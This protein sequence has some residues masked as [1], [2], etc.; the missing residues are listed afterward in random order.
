MI[1]ILYI[2]LALVLG[3][4]AGII[5]GLIPGIHVNLIAVFLMLTLLTAYRVGGNNRSTQLKN[6]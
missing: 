1:E 2:V 5:T 3:I 4:L 6:A